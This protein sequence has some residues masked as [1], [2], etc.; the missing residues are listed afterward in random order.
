ML[1]IVLH[2]LPPLEVYFSNGIY[3]QMKKMLLY[4]HST[5]FITIVSEQILLFVLLVFTEILTFQM[6]YIQFFFLSS[7][8]FGFMSFSFFL[9]PQE[10]N[11]RVELFSR[12]IFF[13]I[14]RGFNFAN[15][16]SLDFSRKFVFG[17]L[18]FSN[19]LHI[20]IFLVFVLQ[21][22]VCESRN[23]CPNFSVFQIL[24]LRY[25]KIN[26]RLFDIL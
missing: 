21:L 18:S 2:L 8:Q 11:F 25:K 6:F 1:K 9:L 17:N 10:I 12:D 19:V 16:I 15:W 5:V 14:S 13:D 4:D 26:S 22:V 3:Y 24:L 20:L 23:F 7:S